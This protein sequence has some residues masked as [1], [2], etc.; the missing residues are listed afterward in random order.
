MFVDFLATSLRCGYYKFRCGKSFLG[1]FCLFVLLVNFLSCAQDC[2]LI[3][4]V[5]PIHVG[6]YFSCSVLFQDASLWT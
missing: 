2:L 6:Y 1:Q 5:A 3:A 4:T